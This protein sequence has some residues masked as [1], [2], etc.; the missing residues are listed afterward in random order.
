MKPAMII[1]FA[2][3]ILCAEDSIMAIIKKSPGCEDYPQAG[4]IILFERITDRYSTRE[5]VREVHLLIKMLNDRGIDEYGDQKVE[6]DK[7]SEEVEIVEARTITPD[8]KVVKPL[9]TAISDVS[10]VSV[11]EAPAY[12]N[13]MVKVVSFPAMEKN[14]VIEYHFRI[15]GKSKSGIKFI[16]GSEFFQYPEPMLEKNFRLIVPDKFEIKH[17]I[18]GSEVEYHQSTANGQ[19]I[20]SWVKRN[21][22]QI[23]LEE[24]MPP[25]EAVATKLIYS[26]AHNWQETGKWFKEKFYKRF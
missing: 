10:A 19:K 21:S 22:E 14:A 17:K 12:A 11:A 18:V 15:R 23:I 16:W 2:V 13:R 9:K 6:Y 4:A 8:L 3:S 24:S 7:S 26:S 20:Y 1:L 25:L 5:K